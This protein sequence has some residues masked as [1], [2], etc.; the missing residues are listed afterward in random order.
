M[1]RSGVVRLVHWAGAA[2][3]LPTVGR[4]PARPTLPQP[5]AG[6][7]RAVMPRAEPSQP[8]SADDAGA[9]D[10]AGVLQRLAQLDGIAERPLSEHAEVYQGLH[11]DLQ[12][13][14]ARIDSA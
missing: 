10:R 3:D 14:L 8:T 9:T 7:G 1:T 5:D 11:A 2:V 6:Y 13:A 4:G 12:A